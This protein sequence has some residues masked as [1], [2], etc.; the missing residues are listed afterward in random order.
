MVY[1]KRSSLRSIMQLFSIGTGSKRPL[2]LEKEIA[3]LD[4][5]D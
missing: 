5:R 1:Q 3:K 4:R 2:M